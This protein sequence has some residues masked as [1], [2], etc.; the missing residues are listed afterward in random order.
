MEREGERESEKQREGGRE[1]GREG[2]R[3]RGREGERETLTATSRV[4]SFS[5]Y[6]SF[7]TPLC[8]CRTTH[9]WSQKTHLQE[10]LAH[11]KQPKS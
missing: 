11:K 7:S 9:M 8:T 2:E 10:Y 6:F 1:G 4:P 3:E 5:V